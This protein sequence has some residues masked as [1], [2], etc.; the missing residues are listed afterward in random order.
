MRIMER[1]WKPKRPDWK[2]KLWYDVGTACIGFSTFGMAGREWYDDRP[3][4]R[5]ARRKEA[6]GRRS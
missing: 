4:A 1:L 3:E 2:E 5:E 6:T